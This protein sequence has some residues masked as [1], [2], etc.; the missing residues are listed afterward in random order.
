M[1]RIVTTCTPP[2]PPRTSDFMSDEPIRPFSKENRFQASDD[3]DNDL[4][5]QR[6]EL[7]LKRQL[8]DEMPL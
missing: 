5:E 8:D 7:L 4:E 6:R 3:D 1:S 2:S